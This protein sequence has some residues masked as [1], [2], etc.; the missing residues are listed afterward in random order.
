[1]VMKKTTTTGVDSPRPAE[2]AS[3]RPR[4]VSVAEAK[5]KLSEVLR[6]LEEGPV[7]IHARG[8]DVGALVDI[9]SYERLAAANDQTDQPGGA[10]FLEAVDALKQRH[11][12][13]VE[14]FA[15][16][17]SAIR[18]QDPFRSRRRG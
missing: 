16:T 7:I 9:D 4:R 17:P 11:G 2:K 12:G 14:D 6:S 3:R 8:R 15:P 10:A 5:A 13:G 18:P 1:M